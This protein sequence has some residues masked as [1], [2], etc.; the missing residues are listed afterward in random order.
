M[1]PTSTSS[2]GSKLGGTPAKQHYEYRGNEKAVVTRSGLNGSPVAV[3]V[4]PRVLLLASA[5]HQSPIPVLHRSNLRGVVYSPAE[6]V[7]GPFEL[8]HKVRHEPLAIVN[9]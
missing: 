8:V 4:S 5:A 9:L 1:E 6:Q 3:P 2:T 7:D